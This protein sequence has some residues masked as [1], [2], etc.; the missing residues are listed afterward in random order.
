ML[1][2]LIVAAVGEHHPGN[3]CNMRWR[4]QTQRAKYCTSRSELQLLIDERAEP[5]SA[6]LNRT[7]HPEGTH[8]TM[9]A[10]GPLEILNSLSQHQKRAIAVR[11]KQLMS[12]VPTAPAASTQRFFKR[13]GGRRRQTFT[14][15]THLCRLPCWAEARHP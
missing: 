8:L 5:A 6:I 13:G 10:S 4:N 1:L 3:G 14:A 7:R 15:L 11:T 12:A 2:L 9:G